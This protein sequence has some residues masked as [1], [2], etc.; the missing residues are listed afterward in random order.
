[1]LICV[2]NCL[3]RNGQNY[4]YYSDRDHDLDGD[5]Y[6]ASTNPGD[7]YAPASLLPGR[8]TP[9]ERKRQQR[10]RQRQGISVPLCTICQK[11]QLKGKKSKE[12]LICSVCWKR[13]D[14]AKQQTLERVR[15]HR[16]S[17][18]PIHPTTEETMKNPTESDT[19][20]EKRL[21]Y[22][23]DYKVKLSIGFAADVADQSDIINPSTESSYSESEWNALTRQQQMDWL[24]A[25]T[26]DWANNYIEYF[27]VEP[28]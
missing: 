12:R 6:R 22:N 1:M 28:E 24:D 21:P 20:T 26:S 7:V 15:Q 10:E 4:V 5:F 14:E 8:T 18:R 9:A 13:T 19:A 27:W 25:A 11:R 17:D 16:A 2:L 3:M 23:Y